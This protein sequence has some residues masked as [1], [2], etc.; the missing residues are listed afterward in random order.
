MR[1]MPALVTVA[2]T[3]LA[4]LALGLAGCGGDDASEAEPVMA[5]TAPATTAPA[6]TSGSTTPATGSG[7][8][9][10]DADPSGS[11][12]FVQTRLTSS[13]GPTTIVFTNDSP[14]PHNVAVEGDGVDTEP[15]ATV[16]GGATARLSVDLPPGEYE[17]YC[18]VPGHRQ[19][20]MVGTL[21]VE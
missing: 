20:G 15:T 6:E 5:T 21:T 11:L 10:I 7:T 17:Y 12:A 18:D 9:A 16:E 13:A 19:A 1:R 2:A 3:A 4:A 14:V 8:L